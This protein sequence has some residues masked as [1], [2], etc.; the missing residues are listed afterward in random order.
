MYFHYFYLLN[1]TTLSFNI[2]FKRIKP[3]RMLVLFA[4]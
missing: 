2:N 1:I 4:L 3:E